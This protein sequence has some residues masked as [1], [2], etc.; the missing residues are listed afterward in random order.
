MVLQILKKGC[1]LGFILG[2]VACS[3]APAPRSGQS[4]TLNLTMYEAA[5]GTTDNGTLD[6]LRTYQMPYFNLQ[7]QIFETLVALDLNTQ[8]IQ[9]LLAESWET[10]SETTLRFHLRRDVRFHNGEPFT[11]AAVK[12]SLDLMLDPQQKFGG[13]FLLDAIAEVRI[14]DDFTVDIGLRYPDARL[15]RRLAVIGF[16]L[17]PQY[18]KNA[19][20]TYF[21]RNPMGTG[22]YRFFYN[23]KS[24]QGVKET[25][26]VA[27]EDYWGTP[28]PTIHEVVYKFIP[29]QQQWQALVNGEVDLLITQA[30][31]PAAVLEKNPSLVIEKKPSLRTAFCLFNID[32]PGPLRDERVRRALEHAVNRQ[33]IIEKVLLGYGKPLYASTAAEGSLAYSNAAPL[34]DESAAKTAEL[35]AAAGYPNGLTLRVMA[36]ANQPTTAVAEM[37]KQQCAQFGITLDVH[38]LSRDEVFQE[39]VAPKLK[40]APRPSA[41]DIWLMSGWPDLF[42]TNGHFYFLF[43]NSQGIFNF[44]ISQNKKSE[45]DALYNK[46]SQSPDDTAL[47]RNLQGLDRYVLEHA[48]V[49][50]LYQVEIMY[51]M[52][53]G[54]NCNPGLNDMPLR[55]KGCSIE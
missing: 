1:I 42:G 17:P 49:L 19:G 35:L 47:V 51:A 15:L 34:Y 30:P 2:L 33:E 52:K 53:K 11:A 3:S 14:V 22:P 36:S 40:G 24:P 16:I 9:P 28:R 38:L 4:T 21:T 44:G 23:K 29:H 32:K 5:L 37:L 31:E 27:N 8:T 7:H 50:P 12:F 13:R 43:I 26:L 48:L 45:F 25:H 46:A 18:F 41:Y 6:P 10:P 55:F 54:V 20:E 39:V